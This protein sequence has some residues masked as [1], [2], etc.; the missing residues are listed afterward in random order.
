[1]NGNSYTSRLADLLRSQ[2]GVMRSPKISVTAKDAV[3]CSGSSTGGIDEEDT[4]VDAADIFF[5]SRSWLR[6]RITTR[7]VELSALYLQGP[8]EP[9]LGVAAIF[10]E[11]IH[12]AIDRRNGCDAS[13]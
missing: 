12:R 1:L 5:P 11:V 8:E 7:V 9:A 6:Y 10:L 13:C 2:R 4:I 3:I